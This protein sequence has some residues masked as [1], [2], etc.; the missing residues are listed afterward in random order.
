MRARD[1][2]LQGYRGYSKVMT[3]TALGSYSRP[4][5]RSIGPP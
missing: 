3:H 2:S 1:L 4:I 5:P